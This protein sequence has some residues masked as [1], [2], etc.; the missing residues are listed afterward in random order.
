MSY[1]AEL[2]TTVT[3]DGF[4]L[5]GSLRRPPAGSS[6]GTGLDV[7]ILHHGI[8]GKFYGS[9]MFDRISAYWLAAGA[10]VLQIGRASCRERV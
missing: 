5:W 1:L 7:V 3:R 4:T 6:S 9:A 8:G 2:V 10:A